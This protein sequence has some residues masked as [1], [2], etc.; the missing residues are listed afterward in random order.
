MAI[1]DVKGYQE[2]S[3]GVFT[4]VNLNTLYP[5]F[6]SGGLTWS[7][8]TVDRTLTAN[9]GCISDKTTLHVL[10]LPATSAVGD[11]FRVAGKNVGGWKVAQNASQ[12]I[13]FQD[14]QTTEGVNGFLRSNSYFDAV[15]LL[16]IVE[17]LVFMV[18]SSMGNIIIY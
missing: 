7:I 18:I 3:G 9:Y 12:Y 14:I 11:V 6:G 5:S 2:V 13:V 15:E 10:T 17:D 1:G 8:A 4:E 16:C